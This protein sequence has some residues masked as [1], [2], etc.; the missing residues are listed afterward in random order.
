M[1]FALILMIKNEERILKRCLEAVSD[2]VDCFCICDTGSTDKTAEVGN[3]FLKDHVGCLTV[4]PWKNFGYNRTVSFENAK[5]YIQDELKWDL[6]ETYGLLLDADMVFVSGSLKKLHLGEVGYSFIQLNSGLEYANTRLV[7]MDFPWKCLGVTHEYWDGPVKDIPKSVCYINDVNDGG[8]KHDKFE[9]DQRLLEQ[10]LIDEPKNVRYM[11]YLAQ[12]YKCLNKLKESIKMYKKRIQAGGWDEEVW[13]SHY[14]IGECHKFLGN[15]TKYEDWMQRA[16]MYRPRRAE[17]LYRLTEFF[18]IKGDQHKAYHYLK[19]G[20][21]IPYPNDLLFVE[22]DVYRGKFDYEASILDYYVH[23]DKKIG[24]KDSIKYLLQSSHLSHNVISNIKFY[25]TSISNQLE[26]LNIPNVFSD[27]FHP[28]AVSIVKYPFANVRFINYKIEKDGSY[29]TPKGIVETRNAYVNLESGETVAGFKEPEYVFDTHIKGLEDLRLYT[30]DDKL[31]FTAT[32]FKQFILDKISIVE[33]EYDYENGVFKDYKGILS[34]FNSDC[35]KNWVNI[36]G[37]D[38]FIYSW[39]PLRTGKIVENKFIYNRE[40]NTPPFFEH[41]RGSSQII[42]W[43]NR[44]L[45]LVHFVEYSIPRKYYHC[46]VELDSNFKPLKITLPF[47]FRD[48][49]IEYCICIRKIDSN[50]ECYVSFN[51]S[52]PHKVIVSENSLEWIDL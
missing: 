8:C 18:R 10:G 44:W 46:F 21:N 20:R 52:D 31:R 5:K 39:S 27:E 38:E 36:Q 41:L 45:A 37:T 11:F 35:E 15:I 4:E 23:D 14:M 12:T 3:E 17:T 29:T 51:D 2:F 16:Y 26:K 25:T 33:G 13:Y 34:P 19:L 42:P 32:S 24:L 40:H 1:K 28:S 9:R 43:N 49:A 48:N 50:I 22:G 30:K 47:Y 6:K 7:R